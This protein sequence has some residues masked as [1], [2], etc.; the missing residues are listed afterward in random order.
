MDPFGRVLPKGS[1]LSNQCLPKQS[2]DLV[3]IYGI[4]GFPDLP[5]KEFEIVGLHYLP[6][7]NEALILESFSV[8]FNQSVSIEKNT[9]EQSNNPEWA[10]LRKNKLTSSRFEVDLL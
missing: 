10:N 6:N 2:D 4:N 3:K 5:I 8:N 7:E 1:I 9:R